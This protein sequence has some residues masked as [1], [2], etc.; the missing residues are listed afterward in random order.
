ME[1]TY[2]ARVSKS[3][4][5]LNQKR[6]RKSQRL[7]LKSIHYLSWSKSSSLKIR[8][9]NEINTKQILKASY[10]RLFIAFNY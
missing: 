5:D 2:Q 7:S 4:N 10:G 1:R 6:F 3:A 9:I 8:P